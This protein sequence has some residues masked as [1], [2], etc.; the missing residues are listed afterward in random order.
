MDSF[1]AIETRSDSHVGGWV[2]T[3]DNAKIWVDVH[4]RGN[5]IVLLHGWTMSSAFW[6]RQLTLSDEY[7]LITIDLRGHGKSQAVLRGN[8]ISRYA[9]DVREVLRALRLR[10]VLLIGWSMGGSVVMDYWQQY[11]SDLLS[12]LGLVETGPAP[13]S[14]APWNLHSYRNHNMEAMHH[15]LA[16]MVR[17]RK[18]YGEAFINAMF[19]SGDAPSH[20]LSWMLKEQLEVTDQTAIAIYKDYIQRDYTSVLPTIS[21][22]ALVI[23]GRSKHMC[24]GPSTG[25]YVAGSIPDSNFVILEQSGHLP[26]YEEPVIF[27]EAIGHFSNRLTR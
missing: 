24:F 1:E 23:Y 16:Y 10:H 11:G 8:T 4:G 19:L 27:N 20:A 22:P 17:N 9:R 18:S 25:R 7:Q 2:T 26:F 13:M 3:T 6:R 12:G 5:P 21:V 14:P 15:D